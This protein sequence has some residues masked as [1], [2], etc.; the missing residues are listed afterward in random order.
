MGLL[1]A[2][3]VVAL[4]VVVGAIAADA[5]LPPLVC[6]RLPFSNPNLA[7]GWGSTCCGRTGPHRGL[8]FPQASGTNIP[9]AADGTIVVKTSTSCL[10]NVVVV[11]HADGMF[12][13]YCHMQAQSPLGL[14]DHVTKGEHIGRVGATGTCQ[15]GA[16]LHLT[17]SNHRD[18]YVTGTTVDPYAYIMDHRTCD[19]LP[20]GA[21]DEVGCDD[22]TGTALDPDTAGALIDAR[23]TFGGPTGSSDAVEVEVE[24]SVVRDADC[25]ADQPCAH[26]FVAA[27]PA[28]MKDDVDHDVYAYGVDAAG[29]TALLTGAPQTLRCAPPAV[30][31][32]A[33]GSVRRL[34]DDDVL[35]AWG[36]SSDDVVGVQ[37][38]AVQALPSSA[39]LSSPALVAVDDALFIKDGRVLRA[40]DEAARTA[41]K[42]DPQAA[43]VLDE[44]VRAPLLRGAPWPAA[45]YL[46]FDGDDD[47]VFVDAPPPLWARLRV[48]RDGVVLPRVLEAG[49]VVDVALTMDNRGSNAWS[50]DVALVPT[51][52]GDGRAFC[53]DAWAASADGGDACSVIA[54]VDDDVA[55]GGSTSLPVRLRAPSTP[56]PRRVCLGL[57][58]GA[59][60]F[61]EAGL[62]GPALDDWCFDV[63]VVTPNPARTTA[64]AVAID[65][66]CASTSSTSS[67]SSTAT[68]LVLAGILGSIRRRRR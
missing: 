56:G 2:W 60:A 14:G 49:A 13:G 23:V 7:D 9:V 16:H 3:L 30:P 6:Y 32:Y 51:T 42:L 48:P 45:P 12:T 59:H 27:V 65:G 19:R 40:L 17:L 10:G 18:G 5:T 22:V 26:G 50:R 1:R 68:W 24:A 39:P 29:R 25:A 34:V 52:L 54:R 44:R 38:A 33:P 55:P 63:L 11:Q 21:L 41:W 62:G 57:V 4:G 20:T 66:G 37:R 58:Q 35:A 36:L 31:T 64:G 46:A 15:S 47:V 43:T 8:D 53:D 28:S 61:A 67:T